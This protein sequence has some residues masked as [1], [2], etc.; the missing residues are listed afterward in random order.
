M[1][2]KEKETFESIIADIIENNYNLKATKKI[3]SLF[4]K[5]TE[6]LTEKNH[7]LEVAN[8]E[9]NGFLKDLEN[10]YDGII[11]ELKDKFNG[12][13]SSIND[14]CNEI[15][16]LQSQLKEKDEDI[17]RLKEKVSEAFDAGV[18][19]EYYNHFGPVPNPMASK[20]QFLKDN[21]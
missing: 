5:H 4:N 3:I 10:R 15:K 19:R 14:L 7:L 21:F 20:E 11:K 13:V 12:Q 17:K 18:H 1:K 8:K 16:S 9:A 2:D 6:H